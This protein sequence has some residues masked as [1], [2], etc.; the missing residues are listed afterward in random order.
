MFSKKQYIAEH[1]ILICFTET[2][3]RKN[4]QPSTSFNFLHC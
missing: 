4:Y 3:V 1:A 2:N